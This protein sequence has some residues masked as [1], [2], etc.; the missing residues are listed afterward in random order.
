VRSSGGAMIWCLSVPTQ[1]VCVAII[2]CRG[3]GGRGEH[4][5]VSVIWTKTLTCNCCILLLRLPVCVCVCVNNC[6]V[7][8]VPTE[9]SKLLGDADAA[10]A[11]AAALQGG[12]S[13]HNHHHQVSILG[14]CEVLSPVRA[15]RQ[16]QQ[17]LG[18]SEQVRGVLGAAACVD[19]GCVLVVAHV[20][21]HGTH[22]CHASSA[23]V[24][25]QQAPF[26]VL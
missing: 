21:A 25:L 6:S 24:L 5:I 7:R 26:D 20:H 15:R 1:P 18:A 8:P 17:A 23:R 9:L 3:A 2:G 22:S 16:V 4:L 11:A 10:A 13:S 19:M 14:S 12:S